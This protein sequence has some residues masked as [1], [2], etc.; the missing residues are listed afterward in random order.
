M[1]LII[2]RR[3]G[4]TGLLWWTAQGSYIVI[5]AW[6]RQAFGICGGQPPGGYISKRSSKEIVPDQLAMMFISE[7]VMCLSILLAWCDCITYPKARQT[8]L[9][10]KVSCRLSKRKIP[11]LSSMTE[12]IISRIDIFHQYLTVVINNIVEAIS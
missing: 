5:M 12:R 11:G 4:W 6:E 9:E 2:G 1:P 8:D 7:V 10:L 3:L